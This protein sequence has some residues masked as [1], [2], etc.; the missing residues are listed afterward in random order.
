M[1]GLSI[2]AKILSAEL[3]KNAISDVTNWL[4]SGLRNGKNKL[5][6]YLDNIQGCGN[7][8]EGRV[9]NYFFSVLKSVLARLKSTKAK[10]EAICLLDAVQ[11]H[12]SGRDFQS[13]SNLNIFKIL[14]VGDGKRKNILKRAWGHALKQK[15]GKKD[16]QSDDLTKELLLTFEN[17]FLNV[18]SRI[19][20]NDTGDKVSVKQQGTSIP[21]F[22]RAKSVI[23]TNASEML[24]G[25][26]FEVL[27][28]ELDRYVQL[29]GSFEGIDWATYVRARNKQKKDG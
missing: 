4:S 25:S 27:F 12:F 10:D 1:A 15:I 3:P 23:D 19:V 8:I 6:H 18:I 22:E 5:S 24:L 11:W 9:R 26:A 2:F 28:K 13:L 17:L 21:Q 29:M 7:H 14:R 20:E 16:E